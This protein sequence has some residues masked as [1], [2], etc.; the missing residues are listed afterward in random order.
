MTIPRECISKLPLPGMSFPTSFA[1]SND[2]DWLA[3]LK[4]TDGENYYSLF[5]MN[6]DSYQEYE[7]LSSIPVTD[8]ENIEEQLRKQR[9]RQMSTGITE[10]MWIKGNKILIPKNGNIY[11]LDT[12]DSDPRVLIDSK[13]YFAIDPKASPDGSNI[14]FVAN[15]DLW[16][17]D[18]NGNDF[19]RQITTGD[20]NK[21]RGLAIILH[22]KKWAD[23]VDIHGHKIQLQ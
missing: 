4:S 5:V 15:G 8:E 11:I 17:V 23:V 7:I 12:F 9:L 1:F 22:K 13:D 3:Y 14:A 21:T 16:I 10:F 6:M 18:V 19:P 2:G 20:K